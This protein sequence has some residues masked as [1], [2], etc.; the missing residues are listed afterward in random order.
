MDAVDIGQRMDR[1]IGV[2]RVRVADE[3][4]ADLAAGAR[5]HE[6]PCGDGAMV[7]REW[8]V[9]GAAGGALVLL[10]GGSGSWRHWGRNIGHFAA[11]RRV[12]APDLPGLGD[13]AS[14]PDPCTPDSIARIVAG[15][16]AA[17]I[18][19]APYHLAGFSFGAMVASRVALLHPGQVRTLTVIGAGAMGT[20]RHALGLEKVRKLEGAA[21]VDAHRANLA[22]LMIADPANI[23][24]LALAIQEVNTRHSRMKSPQFAA[25]T[26]LK[27]A[28]AAFPGRLHGIWGACDAASS[29]SVGSRRD[30]L[31]SVRPD[32]DFRVIEGAGHWVA[33][34]AAGAFNAMLEGIVEAA[35]PSPP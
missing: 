13:S 4:L 8:G 35:P 3:P 5:L 19:T 17:V 9:P 16:I 23:D 11:R 12:I 20:P 15:G 18:G 32:I 26:A 6:A 24:A 21:R 14:P 25:G 29:P 31:R 10:H 28:V 7:L 1:R 30:I 22:K 34:E 2:E 27:D 33:Y